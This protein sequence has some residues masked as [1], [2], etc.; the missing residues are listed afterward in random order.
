MPTRSYGRGPL[1]N[2]TAMGAV[3]STVM[4]TVMAKAIGN[5]G[6]GAGRGPCIA[7]LTAILLAASSHPAFSGGAAD[8]QAASGYAVEAVSSGWALPSDIRFVPHPGEAPGDPLYYV[9]ELRGTIKVV[10]RD[11]SVHV[12]ADDLQGYQPPVELPQTRG[13][14]GLAGI[15]LDPVNGYLFATTIYW[16]NAALYNR[17][18]RFEHDGRRFGLRP[19]RRIEIE[20][21]FAGFTS[22]VSH[23]V[24]KC[25]IAPDSTL[26]V[27][28]GDADEP[29][30]A[31]GLDNPSGKI[32]RM[33]LDGSA[34]QDNPFYNSSDPEAVTNYIYA[35]GLRNPFAI[36]LTRTG[37][38]YAADNGPGHDRLIEVV[39]G[40]NYLWDGKG[41]SIGAGGIWY[42][43]H[44]V[45]PAGMIHLDQASTF[46]R[47]RGSVL[48]AQGGNPLDPGPSRRG[49]ITITR[50]RVRPG[51]GLLD[52][53][54][55]VVSFLGSYHQIL[56]PIAEGPDGLYFSG[57]LPDDTGQ[58]WL[59]RVVR[60]EGARRDVRMLS[61]GDLFQSKGC[62]GCHRVDGLGGN[63]GP[64]LDKLV[65][66]LL[67]RLH[68]PAYEARLRALADGP[69]AV[70]SRQT[71]ALGDLLHLDGEA[72]VQR[73]IEL[74]L[75][76]PRFDQA[77]AQMPNL[78]LSQRDIAALAEWLMTLRN[79]VV[80]T[81]SS[82]ERW[83]RAFRV[84]WDSDPIARPTV[85][86]VLGVLLTLLALG[87]GRRT[88][89]WLRRRT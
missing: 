22:A 52:R 84:W 58:T 80:S 31:Q 29:H 36:A 12:Y 9:A 4:S 19:A 11:G 24:G 43:R 30:R 56:V 8:W 32:L 28:V 20:A 65:D 40:M 34:P 2:G 67:E 61:G 5:V 73:W 83:H 38:L 70:A 62:D 53:P 45:G 51:W 49:N 54:R 86:F 60:R 76:D 74:R 88:R 63:R 66:R 59:L 21:P 79:P 44:S 16:K 42:W 17:I 15:C 77:D 89:R 78:K 82:A 3:M 6:A 26:Y 35:Y 64:A 48:V 55:T 23:Q 50:I 25:V 81:L 69:D 14:L 37:V 39:A 47:W 13:E 68:N 87:L 85:A 57:M 71:P 10:T 27:G 7:V 18:V 46:P 33:N 41:I 1:G 72:R 75:Q